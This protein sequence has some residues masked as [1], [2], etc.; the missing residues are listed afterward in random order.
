M[1]FYKLN[2]VPRW[3]A[4]FWEKKI[5]SPNVSEFKYLTKVLTNRTEFHGETRIHAE[6]II[7]L[8]FRHCPDWYTNQKYNSFAPYVVC[9]WNVVFLLLLL[10]LPL[11]LSLS[12]FLIWREEQINTDWKWIADGY[13]CG[14]KKA[15]IS[16]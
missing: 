6:K 1:A 10:L 4:K 9:V 2:L 12:L 14:S 3:S 7:I 13:M 8:H 5:D 15:E 11:S 16:V